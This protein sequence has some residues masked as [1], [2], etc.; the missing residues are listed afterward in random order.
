MRVS[1][2][3]A[4]TLREDPAEAEVVSHRL[5]L[6]AGFIRKAA[7]GV[8]TY[9]PLGYRVLQKI[10]NIIREE[11]NKAGGQE[12]LLPIIQPAELWQ[13]TGRWDVYG[14]EMFRLNDRHG[15]AFCLGPTHEEIITDLVKNEINSYKQLPLLLY[16]IQNKYRDEKRPR[17]GLM[18]G[19]EFIMKDLYSF[20]KDEEGMKISY[21]KMY[22]AYSNVFRRCGLE[23]RAVEADP[24]AIGGGTSHEFMVLA[25]SGEAVV[26]Y[27]EKCDYAANREK[28]CAKPDIYEKEEM[29]PLELV[30]TPEVRTIEEVA[31]F[32]QLSPKRLIKT[33]FYE[34]DDRLI[35]ALI[36]GDREINEIKLK[37]T[38]GCLHLKLAADERVAAVV[39]AETGF[40]GPVGLEGIDIYAD[41]E[42]AEMSNAVAGANK[43]G[44]H[45]L[46]V[47]PGRDFKV[48]MVVDLRLVQE[49]DS[50]PGCGTPLHA[51]KGIEV[52][53]VFQLGTKY[54]EAIGA[55]YHDEHGE[56]RLMVMGCYGIGVSRTMAAAIE[57]NHDKDGIIWPVAIAPFHVVVI[58]VS[59]KEEEQVQVAEQL[60]QELLDAG[61]E[62]VI[63]DRADRAGVKFKDADLIGYPLRLTVGKRTIE[64]G[65]VDIKVRRT[66]EEMAVPVARVTET[67]RQLLQELSTS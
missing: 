27:C 17:F 51:T 7:A 12:L 57:Q 59:T 60:Y 28:A 61:I 25:D 47:N 30:H 54:S 45:Y 8:Y 9:L 67:V 40:V 39:G 18:R 31:G 23:F 43:N 65:T 5:M 26:V 44:Y 41:P 64:E 33:L 52:G 3:L 10:M 32:L 21:Q 58:P 36:R 38:V 24:G 4:P 19:R 15:R 29:Q 13:Q 53:Q 55:K 49:G 20:D 63:D 6:R 35:C 62:V 22:D 50:C 66:G 11:M 56:E 48:D 16:Q 42:V 14:E 34:A 1:Q 2:L 46:N 37:N